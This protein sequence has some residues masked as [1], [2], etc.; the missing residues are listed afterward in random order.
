MPGLIASAAAVLFPASTLH[1]KTDVPLVLLEAWRESVPVL[2]SDLP[3]LSEL[4]DGVTPALP[5]DVARWTDAVRRLPGSA[6]AWGRLGRARLD[7]RFHAR[8]CAARYAEIYRQLVHPTRR[9]VHAAGTA[10]SMP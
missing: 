7:E 2:V 1:A 3:P 5:P 9:A 8:T 10:V 4:V 6:A